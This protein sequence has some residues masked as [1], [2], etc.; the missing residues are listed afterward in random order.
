MGRRREED[1]PDRFLQLRAGRYHYR[2]RVPKDVLGLDH[3]GPLLR[4][5]LDTAERGKARTARDLHEAAD[6]ALWASNSSIGHSLKSWW[7]IRSR[8][9]CRG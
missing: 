3:R 1:D 4:R 9:C 6:N 2:R 5:A 7:P 8:S